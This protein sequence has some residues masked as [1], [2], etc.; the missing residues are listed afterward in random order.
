MRLVVS[1]VARWTR[2]W[3][4]AVVQA[5]ATLCG[6]PVRTALGALA[7][8]VAVA[9]V[10]AVTAAL[11]G[12]ALFARQS[13]ERAFGANTFLIS[14]VASP[15]RVSRRELQ[16]QLRRNSPITRPELRH[17]GRWAGG[18][19][20]YAP[21][22][23]AAAEVAAGANVFENAAVTGTTAE[24]S[25]LRDLAITRGRFFSSRESDEGAP[26]AVVG[27]DIAEALFPGRDPLGAAVRL[28]M[29][30]FTV[31][32]VQDRL[33]TA[34]GA[35]LDRYVWI[36]LVAFE[37]AFGAP[38]SLQIFARATE[39]RPSFTG[40]DRARVSLRAKRGLGPATPDNFDILTP[41]A[42]RTFVQQL[43]ARIGVAAL[44]IAL[45][46]L[47]TAVVVVTNTVLVSVTERTREIGVRRAFGA[48]AAQVRREVVAEALIT[49]V[50]GGVAGAGMTALV[51]AALGRATPVP[52][53]VSATAFAGSL[54]ISA[55]AGLV[56]A[57]Y[58]AWLAT[59]TDVMTALRAE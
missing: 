17:L 41:E 12:V 8:A 16:E 39:G 53:G 40:E 25:G 34:G 59:R 36:P 10:V 6:R 47:L 49:A 56:A 50:A 13:S 9:G 4:S 21:T 51:V 24:L 31:I 29:R 23:Q 22:A 45:A 38:R 54:A 20:A 27:A 44:P 2:A 42:A 32:G 11:D 43:S 46:A 3:R 30:R 48:A 7:T 52:V 18:L 33:G 37:R 57:W 35:S 58:P 28:A 55:L 26:V 14:Q 1:G 15:G 5:T 19:V